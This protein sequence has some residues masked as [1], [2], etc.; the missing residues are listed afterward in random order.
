MEELN[1]D[2]NERR[3]DGDGE[4]YTFKDYVDF[5]GFKIGLTRWQTNSAEQPVD[6]IVGHPDSRAEQSGDINDAEQP[7]D[8]IVGRPQSRAEQPEDI[9][10]AAQPVDISAS[11]VRSVVQPDRIPFR[12]AFSLGS[13]CWMSRSMQLNKRRGPLGPFDYMVS[14]MPMVAHILRDRFELF[15]DKA[16]LRRQGG[17]WGHSVYSSLVSDSVLFRHSKPSDFDAIMPR[18]V[19]RLRGAMAEPFM[20]IFLVGTTAAAYSLEHALGLRGAL[21]DTGVRNF[22]LIVLVLHRA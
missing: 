11:S 12:F 17:F 14:N 20:K 21:L 8:T 16:N 6:T 7:V 22:N 15:L 3:V 18:R 2:L 10:S 4:A 13:R 19:D 5:Y 9:N 1:V